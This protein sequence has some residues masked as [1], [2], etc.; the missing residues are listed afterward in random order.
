LMRS[1]AAV[2]VTSAG[3]FTSITPSLPNVMNLFN[4]QQQQ[5]QQQQQPDNQ[6]PHTCSTVT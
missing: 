6:R 4:M 1:P 5:Q 3:P 2:G